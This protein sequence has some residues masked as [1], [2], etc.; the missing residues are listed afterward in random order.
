MKSATKETHI[1]TH[2]SIMSYL[3]FESSLRNG[4]VPFPGLIHK[5]ILDLIKNLQDLSRPFTTRFSDTLKWC[6][7]LFWLYMSS[8]LNVASG[9]GGRREGV[10]KLKDI[11]PCFF[12]VEWNWNFRSCCDNF[13][14]YFKSNLKTF[15]LMY[16]SF[17]DL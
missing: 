2:L 4:K 15:F 5:Y 16:N 13:L 8:I 6:L 9:K 14:G 3:K 1:S 11:C 17:Q 12:Q 10:Q 7:K